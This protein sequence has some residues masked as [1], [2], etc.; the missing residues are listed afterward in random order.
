MKNYNFLKS[1]FTILI[2]FCSHVKSG[3]SEV[4]EPNYDFKYESFLD[5]YPGKLLENIQKKNGNGI[6]ME[7]GDKSEIYKYYISYKSYNFPI[8]IQVTKGKVTDFF[9][10]LPSYFLHDVFHQS[11]INRLGKQDIYKKINESAVY[12]WRNQKNLKHVYHGACTITCFPI[13]YSVIGLDNPNDYKS[14]LKKY[15]DTPTSLIGI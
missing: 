3:Q 7:K 13:F 14:L 12:I 15:Q 10:N 11:L 9:T 2:L 6:L 4:R 1:L 8:L 5:F